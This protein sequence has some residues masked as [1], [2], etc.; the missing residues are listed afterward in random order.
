MMDLT[1]LR[2]LRLGKLFYDRTVRQAVPQIYPST[3]E[4][5]QERMVEQLCIKP[6]QKSLLFENF[7]ICRCEAILRMQWK[8][9]TDGYLSVD[10]PKNERSLNALS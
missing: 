7:S 2:S 9:V 6:L 8:A 10:P 3:K 5:R 1:F 4:G